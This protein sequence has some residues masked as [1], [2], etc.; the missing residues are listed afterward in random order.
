M[1]WFSACQMKKKHFSRKWINWR[2]NICFPL[3]RKNEATPMK[4]PFFCIFLTEK[5][6]QEF[7]TQEKN[8]EWKVT[9]LSLIS[10]KNCWIGASNYPPTSWFHSCTKL[11]FSHGTNEKFSCWHLKGSWLA[12][13]GGSYIARGVTPSWSKLSFWFL[14]SIHDEYFF[15]QGLSQTFF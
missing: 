6:N 11:R 3:W 9:C 4:M 14:P 7:F 12:K 1:L 10:N 15:K 13:K 5:V 8:V 2:R